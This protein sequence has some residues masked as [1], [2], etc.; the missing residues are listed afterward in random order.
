LSSS[1]RQPVLFVGHGSPMNAI[2][3]TPWSRAWRTLGA[4][5]R[6]PKAILAVSAHWYGAGTFVTGQA[7]PPTIH[8]FGGFPRALSEV[9]YPAKGDPALARRV[10]DLVRTTPPTTLSSAWGLDH[11][12]WSVLVHIREQ[13]DVPVIQLSL[14]ARIPTSEHV[15]IGKRLAP[16]RNEGVL[17]VASGNVTHNLRHAMG[18]MRSGAPTTLVAWAKQFDDDVVARL[19]ARDTAGLSR[20]TDTEHGRMSHP[21]PDHWLPMLYAAGAGGDDAVSYPVEGFDLG[22]LS[23]RCVRWG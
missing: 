14:D 6:T 13:A 2:E 8:D 22:S 7:Q 21:T 18:V 23:M 17:I 16:L 20:L 19:A 12:T 10:A 5:L 3:T 11:G 15:E 9:Q 4:S 1:S